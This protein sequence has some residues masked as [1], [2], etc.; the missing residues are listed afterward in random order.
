MHWGWGFLLDRYPKALSVHCDRVHV[1]DRVSGYVLSL[2]VLAL[3]VGSM[4]NYDHDY[5]RDRGYVHDHGYA[6]DPSKPV[7]AVEYSV[8]VEYSSTV[9]YSISVQ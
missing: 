2:E 6:L 4:A 5:A 3:V 7:V 8:S 1:R 9:E